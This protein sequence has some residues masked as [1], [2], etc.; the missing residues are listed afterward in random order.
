LLERAPRRNVRP[1]SADLVA[2]V[3]AG[4][5]DLAWLYASVARANGLAAVRLPS[6][7]DLGSPADSATYA[8]GSVRIAGRTHGDTI[9]VRGRPIRFALTVPADAPHPERGAAF[10]AFLLSAKGRALLAREGLEVSDAPLVV[11]TG[12]P[13]VVT[14]ALSGANAP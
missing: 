13:P 8:T 10:A 3:Q 9:V 6:A 7:I 1:K 2:L 12:V 14:A 4:E 11:G 5:L